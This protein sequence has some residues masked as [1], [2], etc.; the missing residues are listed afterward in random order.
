[1]NAEKFCYAADELESLAARLLRLARES[2]EADDTL[3]SRIGGD[4]EQGS[5]DEAGESAIA[6]RARAKMGLRDLRDEVLILCRAAG[7]DR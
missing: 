3:M 6:A 4:E 7:V 5:I 2:R 1:M